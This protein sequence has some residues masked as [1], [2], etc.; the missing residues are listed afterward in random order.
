MKEI[1]ER[2]RSQWKELY[3]VFIYLEKA[4]DTVNREILVRLLRHVGVDVKLVNVIE[5]I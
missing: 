3:L 5:L 4:Y 2:N 1:I